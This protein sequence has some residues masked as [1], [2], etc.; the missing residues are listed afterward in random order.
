MDRDIVIENP[1]V[2]KVNMM[3]QE[4][5]QISGEW[6]EVAHEKTP[7]IN[8]EDIKTVMS[9]TGADREKALE[10]IKHAEGDLAKAILELSE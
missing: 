4:T 5:W 7:E 1:Q 8:E 9:Q 10:A 2:A 3:G 6:R